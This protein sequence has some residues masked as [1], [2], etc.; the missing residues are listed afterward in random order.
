MKKS[1]DITELE[2]LL[3]YLNDKVE[4]VYKDETTKAIE[5]YLNDIKR[6]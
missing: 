5:E 1:V 6:G 3:D 4:E 2:K